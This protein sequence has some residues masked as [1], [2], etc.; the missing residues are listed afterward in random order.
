MKLLVGPGCHSFGE[1]F[2]VIVPGQLEEPVVPEIVAPG[3]STIQS[4]L[5]YRCDGF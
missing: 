2:D 5:R 4:D 3:L 1:F